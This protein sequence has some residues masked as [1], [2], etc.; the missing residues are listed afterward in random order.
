M[1]RSSE[2]HNMLYYVNSHSTASRHLS[3]FA[4][5]LFLSLSLPSR[6]AF[7]SP[8]PSFPP[9]SF[10]SLLWTCPV[11]QVGLVGVPEQDVAKPQTPRG[12]RGGA[13]G[14]DKPESEEE[15]EVTESELQAARLLATR[16]L[17]SNV[18]QAPTTISL[19]MPP[20]PCGPTA[21]SLPAHVPQMTHK[22]SKPAVTPRSHEPDYGK[23]G[24]KMGDGA[25]GHQGH[26]HGAGELCYVCHQRD[27]TV[28]DPPL[29]VTMR[30]KREKELSQ[31]LED[32]QRLQ[33]KRTA[34]IQRLLQ[35]SRKEALAE[36]ASFNASVRRAPTP[37]DPEPKMDVFCFRPST[38]HQTIRQNRTQHADFLAHQANMATLSK[39]LEMKHARKMEHE[40]RLS[41]AMVANEA[42]LADRD[43]KR[44]T[45]AQIASDL[46]SQMASKQRLQQTHRLEQLS[47]TSN[48]LPRPAGAPGL[49]ETYVPT[50][51]VIRSR[52]E[53]VDD[54]VR[55]QL[56]RR[57]ERENAL[58]L[59]QLAA[60][61]QRDAEQQR[62]REKEEAARMLTRAK[63]TLREDMVR[64][65]QHSQAQRRELEDNWST[66]HSKKLERETQELS[67]IR[68]PAGLPVLEQTGQYDRCGRCQRDVNNTGQSFIEAGSFVKASHTLM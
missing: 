12:K 45:Q 2:K 34:R 4:S 33:E 1:A 9:F 35:S 27:R 8:L 18:F 51:G 30:S 41:M 47:Q 36:Q 11:V 63:E 13:L 31:R 26:R 53:F 44:Q 29:E 42:Q 28:P 50:H 25:A 32:L 19:G 20:L 24:V 48:S 40:Q 5:F 57:L 21:S 67:H 61:R 58:H 38:S 14:Q 10:S 60:S 3:L 64:S 37:L 23:K 65:R 49:D 16:D 39:Y 55:E 66:E 59:R 56:R 7:P 54:S 15:V 46:A 6:S 68:A 43:Q 22:R 17:N 52:D 62:Q